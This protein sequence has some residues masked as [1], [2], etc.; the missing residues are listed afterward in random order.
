MA[1]PKPEPKFCDVCGDPIRPDNSYDICSRSPSPECRRELGRRR[2]ARNPSLPGA[3]RPKVIPERFCEICSRPLRNDN[4]TGLCGSTASPE[5]RRER[6]RR[7][8]GRKA[9][10]RKAD[11]RTEA[12]KCDVCGSKINRSNR[13]GVCGDPWKPECRR[14][15]KRRKEVGLVPRVSR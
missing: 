3:P 7:I 4:K 10:E 5:C 14:E 15:R 1:K 11:P 13:Y 2:R 6:S 12:P 9:A 8:A